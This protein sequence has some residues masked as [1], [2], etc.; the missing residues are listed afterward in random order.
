MGNALR[1]LH[2]QA[3][4]RRGAVAMPHPGQRTLLQSDARTRAASWM[5]HDPQA[6][7]SLL[8]RTTGP[9]VPV[10]SCS[11]STS[12]DHSTAAAHSTSRH[13]ATSVDAVAAPSAVAARQRIDLP[14]LHAPVGTGTPMLSVRAGDRPSS[15]ELVPAYAH[16]D[17]QPPC[18]PLHCCQPRQVAQ[19]SP[20][21][22]QH[23]VEHGTARMHRQP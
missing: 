23:D 7:Q 20:G 1:G 16:S 18:R 15:C 5:H 22:V 21:E 9:H 8:S 19:E 10:S 12:T 17:R 11:T 13:S 14:H 4:V 2:R 3:H 6:R